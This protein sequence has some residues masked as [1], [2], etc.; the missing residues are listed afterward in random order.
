MGFTR[1]AR[2]TILATVILLTALA[3]AAWAAIPGTAEHTAPS[4][5]YQGWGYVTSSGASSVDV[6]KWASTGWVSSTFPTGASV[7]IYPW[8]SGWSWVW[9]SNAWYAVQTEHTATWKCDT[10]AGDSTVYSA[11]LR[12]V[13]DVRQYNSSTSA[14]AGQARLY[15]RIVLQCG[16]GF[17]DSAGGGTVYALVKVQSYTWCSSWTAECALSPVVGT[18]FTGY[19]D[20]SKLSDLPVA[21]PDGTFGELPPDA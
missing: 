15:D 6:W 5:T 3:T 16:N 9:R 11:T 17:A 4:A 1:I 19:I 2:T 20:T 21:P 13:L 14:V 10:V 7:W 8:G 18:S 12:T